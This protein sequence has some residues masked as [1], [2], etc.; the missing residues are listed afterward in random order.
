MANYLLDAVQ[1]VDL[2]ER[3]TGDKPFERLEDV[4]S[5]DEMKAIVESYQKT[6]GYHV[7]QVSRS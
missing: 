1:E 7:A 4:V 6:A 3:R 5:Q 2:V